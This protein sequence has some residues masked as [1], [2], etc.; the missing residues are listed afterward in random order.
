MTQLALF[1]EV[2]PRVGR[3]LMRSSV[4]NATTGL[5]SGKRSRRG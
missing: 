1:Q 4:S 3:S 2:R 5:L